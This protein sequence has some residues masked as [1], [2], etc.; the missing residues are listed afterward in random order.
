MAMVFVTHDL[1]VVAEIADRALVMQAGKV[2][3]AGAVDQILTAPTHPYTRAL[4]AAVPS[5]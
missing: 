1:G 5:P 2:V 4:I 3:E